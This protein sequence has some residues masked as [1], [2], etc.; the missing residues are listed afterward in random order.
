MKKFRVII[1][2]RY[3]STRLP[4]K[5]LLDIAGKTMLQ[6]VYERSIASGAASVVIATDDARIA[7][8]A[9]SFGAEVCMTAASHKNGT[10]R[11]AEA[12]TKLNYPDDEIV[13]NV[14]GDEPLIP[15][16]II[17]QIALDLAA[18]SKAEVATLCEPIKDIAQI[19][20]P[21]VVKIVM[22]RLGYALYFSRAPI[23]WDRDNFS[24]DK[25]DTGFKSISMITE[26]SF[27]RH[28]G[29]YAYRVGFLKDYISW[30]DCGLENLER[31][32]QLRILWNGVKIHVAIAKA[33]S[34][35]G[36]DT[37][38]DLDKVR[39]LIRGC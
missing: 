2:V 24:F 19:F 39:K 34:A 4:K 20:S 10:E 8:T 26:G 7:D 14:Q 37:Q 3:Y 5:A 31:L 33:P 11:L 29:M 12:I 13:V 36:V 22:D 18:H 16:I 32:E 15:P 6:H 23:P 25:V 38:E 1:P 27:Y 35:L 17:E 30:S 21:N 28:I 9:H